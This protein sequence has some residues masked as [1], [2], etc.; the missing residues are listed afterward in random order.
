VWWVLVAFHRFM[1]LH[2][3]VYLFRFVTLS[4]LRDNILFRNNRDSHTLRSLASHGGGTYEYFNQKT[5]FN[6]KSKVMAPFR[7]QVCRKCWILGI[8]WYDF[9]L[10][11]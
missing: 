5:K 4:W 10:W 9:T 11:L 2:V 8:H 3:R 1:Y 6:W 7:C